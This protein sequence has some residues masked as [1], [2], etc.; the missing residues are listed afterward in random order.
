M[1]FIQAANDYSVEPAKEL[2]AR[3]AGLGKSYRVKI[4]PPIGRTA[5]DG[6][7]LIDLGVTTW[8]ADVFAF[9]GE[10]MRP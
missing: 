8:E 9:L 4:H 5:A 2:S 10:H 3:M 1:F 7:H 6:H